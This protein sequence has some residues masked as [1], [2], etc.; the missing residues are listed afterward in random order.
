MKNLFLIALLFC[1]V[2]KANTDGDGGSVVGDGGLGLYCAANDN[3][4]LFDLY[5]EETLFGSRRITLDEYGGS[6]SSMVY[7]GLNRLITNFKLNSEQ[8]EKIRTMFKHFNSLPM[9]PWADPDITA[10]YRRYLTAN[11]VHTTASVSYR[12]K[13]ERCRMSVAVINPNVPQMKK[14]TRKVYKRICAYGWNSF[15]YCLLRNSS[16]LGKLPPEHFACLVVHEALRFLPAEMR[17]A[18]EF[19]LRRI[20][21][22]ICTQ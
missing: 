5:E 13:I 17:P 7:T 19:Q 18:D 15:D 9:D 4:V 1:L 8:S 20:T 12:M 6:L 3:F 22:A 11:P 16:V 10:S 14:Q 2:A 21:A